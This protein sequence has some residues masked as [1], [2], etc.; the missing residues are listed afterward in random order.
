M[1]RRLDTNK[2]DPQLFDAAS[3]A[4]PPPAGSG[5]D[6]APNGLE[7]PSRNQVQIG[8]AA[9]PSRSPLTLTR[10]LIL[11][12]LLI[13]LQYV[14]PYLLERYQYALTRGRQQAEYDVAAKELRNLQLASLSKASQLVS[15]KVGPSVVHIDVTSVRPQGEPHELAKL[16]G[17]RNEPSDGQGSGVI[18]DPQGYIV[19]NWHVVKEAAEIAVSLSDG[20]VLSGRI[21]GADPPTDVAVLKIAADGLIAAPWGDSDEVDMGAWVWAVGSPFGLQSSVTFGIISAKHRGNMAGDVYQD[22]LQT[23]AALNPGNSGGPL[24]DAQGRVIGINTAIVGKS[25]QGVCFA[26]PSNVAKEIYERLKANGRLAR[27]WL[28]V[29]LDDVTE[30]TAR[31]LGLPVA[32]GAIIV[33][34]VDDLHVPSPAKDAGLQMGDVVVSWNGKRVDKSAELIRMVA[35]TEIGSTAQ[36]ELIRSGQKLKMQVRV[37]ERPL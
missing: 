31:R 2:M 25:Y 30:P 21:V 6:P 18:V 17:S 29:Q 14:V 20:R 5:P 11:L 9:A 19:T 26:V 15:Q 28:G 8:R 23:D 37:A 7:Q 35:M 13:V 34:V 27:G 12:G 10:I 3:Q 33:L 24:V 16:Y 36:V 1:S 32:A 22:Y 4:P